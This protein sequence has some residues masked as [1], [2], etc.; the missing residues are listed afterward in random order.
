MKNRLLSI[1]KYYWLFRRRKKNVLFDLFLAM[2]VLGLIAA[3]SLPPVFT[4]RS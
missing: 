1:K 4:V 2:T 3:F